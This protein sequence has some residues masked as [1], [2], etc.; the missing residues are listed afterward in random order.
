MSVFTKSYNSSK[1]FFYQRGKIITENYLEQPTYPKVKQ[2][3]LEIQNTSDIMKDYDLYLVGDILWGFNTDDVSIIMIGNP[4]SYI[5][6]EDYMH[7]MYDIALNKYNISIDINWVNTKPEDITYTPNFDFS[8]DNDFLRIGYVKTQIGEKQ[9]ELDLRNNPSFLVQGDYLVKGN[10]K[11]INFKES[12]INKIKNTSNSIIKSTFPIKEF[13]ENDE[14]Y[15]L[16]N[17]NKLQ[18]L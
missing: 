6:L 13:L 12:F 10:F 5:V 1:Y 9:E 8:Y 7:Y 18:Y 17:T 14:E 4:T 11:N 15:F 3:L 2:F 16:K